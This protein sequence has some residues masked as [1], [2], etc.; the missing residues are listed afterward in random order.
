MSKEK[1]IA[2]RCP[3]CGAALVNEAQKSAAKRIKQFTREAR[4]QYAD[5]EYRL[6][7]SLYSCAMELAVEA[8]SPTMRAE[9]L[10]GRGECYEALDERD[11]ALMDYED[12]HK[13]DPDEDLYLKCV[14]ELRTA[15]DHEKRL[16]GK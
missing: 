15:L 6:A 12:A 3:V 9:A 2:K 1:K 4:K 5:R 13:I 16:E 8:A 7:A 10:W 11:Y 14:A